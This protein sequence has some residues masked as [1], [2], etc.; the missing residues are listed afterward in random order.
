MPLFAARYRYTDDAEALAATRPAHRAYLAAQP[1]LMGSGPTDDNGAI[2]VFRAD[3]ASAVEAVLDGDPFTAAGVV[4]S[5][6]VVGWDLVL[7]P[8]AD[9]GA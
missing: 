6:E 7:G 9:G 8:W 1:T 4:A 3:S 5:R 2:L